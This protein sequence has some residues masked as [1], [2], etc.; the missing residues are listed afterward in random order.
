[1]GRSLAW[2]RYSHRSAAWISSVG[3]SNGNS[4]VQQESCTTGMLHS[5]CFPPV[6]P[7]R[8]PPGKVLDGMFIIFNVE[9]FMLDLESS[10]FN[11]FLSCLRFNIDSCNA[12]SRYSVIRLILS[13][14]THS[15]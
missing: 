4:E 9:S 14:S 11:R 12:G 6:S 13:Q 2:T 7:G 10:I 1:M 3:T 5:L 8:T 15:S